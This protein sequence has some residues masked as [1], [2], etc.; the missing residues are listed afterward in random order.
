MIAKMIHLR[1][2]E[3]NLLNVIVMDFDEQAVAVN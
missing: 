1:P 2:L 3:G